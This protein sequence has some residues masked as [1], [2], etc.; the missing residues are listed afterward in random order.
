MTPVLELRETAV[1]YRGTAAD[2]VRDVSLAVEAGESLALVGESGAGKTTLLR[3]LLGLARPTA[4]TVR[5]DGADLNPRDREQMR[6]F[7]RGVQCVFQDPY[8]SLDPSRRVG[9]IVAEPLRSLGL[10]TRATAAPKVAEA[11]ERVGL[12]ADAVDRYPH[13][14]SGGQRQRI[15]IARATVC[16]PRV[17]L[18]D[19][20]VSALDVTT[21]VKVVD[22]LAELKGEQGLTLVMVSHD[23]SVVAS[24]CERTAVLERGRVVEQGAT[25]QVLGEPAHPYTR[26]L[27][28]SVPR[29]PA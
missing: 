12:Q 20:P 3:L 6:R 7:R 8:S 27:I 14:F 25:S 15:A 21:R 29:L 17:L 19:E 11:L 1:R 5:F 16:D 4:G 22:L 24:L 18:A 10:D 26:R 13:E 28:E 2:V 23:L 9:A